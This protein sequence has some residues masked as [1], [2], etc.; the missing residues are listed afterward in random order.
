MDLITKDHLSKMKTKGWPR[1]L[2]S[3]SSSSLPFVFMLNI[4][5][6]A[7]FLAAMSS[8]RSDLV[9]Q[10]IRLSVCLYPYFYFEALEA[11][12][13]VL[14]FLVYRQCF[15]SVSPVFH[16]RFASVSQVFRQCFTNVSAAFQQCF[17]SVSPVFHQYFTIVSPGFVPVFNQ[18]LTSV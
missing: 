11:N 8:S 7:L 9:T 15:T 17:A 18:S 16:Q 3:F 6:N 5:M 4:I 1:F 12:H 10:S 2:K 14:M 13:D